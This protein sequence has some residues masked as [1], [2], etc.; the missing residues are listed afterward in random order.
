MIIDREC[1]KCTDGVLI[2][3]RSYARNFRRHRLMGCK[4]CDF[5][6][7]RP[8]D[9]ISNTRSQRPRRFDDATIKEIRALKGHYGRRIL[10]QRYKC[11]EE[12]IRAIWAGQI[13]RDLLP[14][15]FRAP[16]K[17]GDPNCEHCLHWAADACGM[18]F[19][20]PDVEGPS[21]ARDCSVFVVRG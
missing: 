13:Y 14:D 21:F 12:L 8:D 20:D 11:S 4:S 15:G 7:W 5:R 6:E 16:P 17:P 10:A 9:D 2:I 19:P 1:P 18:G 3:V